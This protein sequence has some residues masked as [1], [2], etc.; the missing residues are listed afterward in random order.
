MYES[1]KAFE[2]EIFLAFIII[3]FFFFFFFFGKWNKGRKVDDV[4]EK[5]FQFL[6][7]EELQ[8]DELPPFY[9][10]RLV[11]NQKER[12]IS[13]LY[14][15]T[16]EDPIRVNGSIGE[17]LY[18]SHLRT[19]DGIGFIGHRLGSIESIDVYEVCSEDF[20]DWRVLFF[21][22]YWL[23]KDRCAPLG[24][25]IENKTPFISAIN[26]FSSKFPLC[27][28]NDLITSTK[29]LVGFPAVRTTIKDIDESLG[30]RPSEHLY[31]LK[32]VIV[33]VRGEGI[34]DDG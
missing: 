9:K 26:K 3:F 18:I 23:Q 25:F 33:Q 6:L 24:L 2:L 15:M 30:K 5:I 29:K 13:K 4:F 34:G 7:N 27:F 10:S 8:N 19:P 17:I 16:A 28:W 21:D 22:L 1:V 11:E 20:K 12:S 31:L 14:G 32:S